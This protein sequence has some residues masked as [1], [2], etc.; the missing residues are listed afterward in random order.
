MRPRILLLFTAG[1]TMLLIAAWVVSMRTKDIGSL[2]SN[3]LGSPFGH[4]A[5]DGS[6]LPVL[7]QAM[8]EFAG[9]ETWLNSEPLT[10]ASLKGKV[11]LVDFWTYSCIN[12]IR[13][14]PYVTSW[15]EKYKEKGFT[16]IGVHTPEFAFEKEPEN[17]RAAVARHGI[18]YPVPLDNDYGTWNAYSN[19]YWPAHYLFDAQ[20]RLRYVHFGEGK[21]D[22]TERN[23]QALLEEAGQE[24]AMAVTSVP[25][26]TDFAKIGSPETYLGYAR[27][28]GTGSPEPVRRD[29]VQFY[30]APEPHA[31]N[32]FQ[33]SGAWRVEEERAVAAGDTSA[34]FYRYDASNVNLVLSP[35]ED[36][37]GRVRVFIDGQDQGEITIDGERLYELHSTPGAYGE[38]LLELRFLTPGT[39]AYAF[40]FG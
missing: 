33:F 29:E 36:R 27:M 37:A 4:V 1:A 11:V 7:A 30:T 26:K 13:T 2:A 23:I 19:Q 16:V 32:R 34:I 6:S 18:T 25:D 8:P 9:I 38:H 14:L 12:C 17:V 24:A 22:E 20:G 21:Y 28:G 35:P 15:H 39:A 10:A 5:S 3:P 40:T 31:L